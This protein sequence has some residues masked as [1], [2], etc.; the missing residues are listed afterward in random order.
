MAKK[1]YHKKPRR[2]RKIT[3]V[4]NLKNST[5]FAGA[6]M[7]MD[8][9][10]GTR[11]TEQ[12]QN[13]VSIVKRS[14]SLYPMEH[15]LTVLTIGRLLGVIRP[16]HFSVLERDPLLVQKLGVEKLSDNTILY[17][18]LVRFQTEEQVRELEDVLW[19]YV[20]RCLK[21]LRYVILDLDSTVETVFGEQEGV[22]VGYNPHKPG[23]GSYHP[24]LAF[25][26]KSR[27]CLGGRLRWGNAHTAAGFKEFYRD[28]K[29]RLPPGVTIRIVRGDH[30]FCGETP[31][32]FF[33]EEGVLYFIKMKVTPR[34]VRAAEQ[35]GFRKL[36]ETDDGLVIEAT[37]IYYQATSW[38][39]E[40]RVVVI[41]K[42]LR[43]DLIQ[44]EGEQQLLW[45]ELGYEYEA[46]VTAADWAEGD[47]YD[48]YN[49]RANCENMI[50]E[51][52][53][54][55][56]IDQ[57]STASFYANYA[58]FL[59]KLIAYNLFCAFKQEAFP[60]RHRSL[61]LAVVRRKFFWITGVLVHHGKRILRLDE[62]HPW[63]KEWWEIR[64]KLALGGYG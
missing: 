22:E 3:E 4:F 19:E 1:S 32:S 57:I 31:L 14:D 23:R 42:R 54:G 35:E 47:V 58:D 51:G 49:H 2:S 7:L 6:G 18:D 11:L 25:D 17:K 53:R 55:L 62:N 38:K 50:K 27:V 30:G 59:I 60:K 16:H 29:R 39:K 63:Q 20:Y 10:I 45:E 21:G 15:Q 37:S 48:S 36:Y 56:G 64:H 26:G 5:H 34:L 61:T 52:K 44:R 41:R 46:V 13:A 43:D 9:I 24:L 40:R 28:I 12:Y 8:Y 33:E